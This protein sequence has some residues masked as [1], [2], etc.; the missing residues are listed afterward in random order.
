[1]QPGI[2]CAAEKATRGVPSVSRAERAKCSDIG[3]WPLT[4]WPRVAQS[5]GRSQAPA[6]LP[7]KY[8]R[9]AEESAP[10]SAHCPGPRQFPK[11]ASNP[12][13]SLR[14]LNLGLQNHIGWARNAT[15]LSNAPEM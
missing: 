8:R 15:I 7:E 12:Y 3:I 5:N 4:D 11:V 6:S 13:L 14:L 2:P 1:W 10:R 9:R